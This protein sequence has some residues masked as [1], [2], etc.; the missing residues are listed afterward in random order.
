MSTAFIALAMKNINDILWWTLILTY[1]RKAMPRSETSKML[2]IFFI[3]VFFAFLIT[4]IP[5]GVV[6]T[7]FGA[8]PLLVLTLGINL[9]ILGILVF[10]NVEPKPIPEEYKGI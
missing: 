7:L 3:V 8:V 10:A 4:P 2:S 9:I 6:Y 1:L 5:S